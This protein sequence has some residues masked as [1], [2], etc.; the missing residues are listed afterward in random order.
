MP[1]LTL[2]DGSGYIFRAFHALPPLRR[3][4]GVPVGAVYGFCSMLFKTLLENKTDSMV[5]V[6]DA[7]RQT[8]RQDIYPDYKAH[9][10]D[11]PEDLIPQF[12]IIRDACSAFNVPTIESVG[13]EADDL[14][15]TYAHHAR[16][17]GYEVCII[18]S[19]KDLMQL[20]SH[21]ISMLDPI[22]NRIIGEAEVI[23]K[24]GVPPSKVVDVQALA[25]DSSDNVPGVPGI[26]V[27]TAAELI[28]TYG[29]LEKLLSQAHEI[30]QPKRREAIIENAEK[31]RISRQLVSLRLDAPIPISLEDLKVR[32]TEQSP[33]NSFLRTQGFNSLIARIER[34]SNS[35]A[36]SSNQELPGFSMSQASKTQTIYQTV[37]TIESLKT[38]VEKAMNTPV[39]AIDTETT[40]LNAIQAQLVGISLAIG[41][42]QACYIPLIHTAST[43]QLDTT[44]ALETLKPL[45]TNPCVLK[46]GHNIKYDLVVLAK[47]GID[48]A[49]LTDT[50]LMSY[51]LDAGKNGHGMDELAELHLGYNTIKF[52]DV[53]GSGKAMKTFDHVPIDQ[54]TAYAA[55]DADVTLQLFHVFRSRLTA[56]KMV[57]VFERL[58][59]PLVAVIASMESQGIQVD[60]LLL[61]RLGHEFAN[62]M[63]QLEAM[64]YKLAGR[65][66]NVA[67]PKQLGE[68]LFDE[69]NLNVAQSTNGSLKIKPPKKTKTGAYVTDVDVLESLAAQGHELPARVLEWRGLAKLK[70]TYVDALIEAVSPQTSRVHTSYML[71]GTSTGRIASSDPNLQNIPIRTEN[72]RK[73]R[74]AFVASPQCRLVSL[75]YSQIELRLLAHMAEVPALVEAFRKG[76]DIHTITASTMFGIAPEEI[77][78]DL[79][80]QAKAINFGII[81][82]IS[83]FGLSHQL[84]IAQ[85]KAADYIK[86]Y[87][88]TYP[89][90]QQYMERC[91]ELARRNGYVQTLW[92][93]KC[94]TLGIQDNNPVARQFAER[95]AINAPLQGSNADIIKRAMIHIP[96]LLQKLKSSAHMLLQVHDELVFEVPEGELSE[97][98]PELKK[99]MENIVPLKVPLV[100]GVGIGNNWDEAH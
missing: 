94:Y 79:R 51:V 38:W 30:K 6:F 14:I 19:D 75:D 45:L 4:D 76:N 60:R 62:Q 5:V 68:I 84:G 71:A 29:D 85:S 37:T 64:I 58:E 77:T 48:I 41:K 70:S 96:T 57:N 43:P 95:Q 88:E 78:A 16:D 66:F 54:A 92:G 93:R 23:E 31:A 59:R 11:P 98:I 87:F 2:I 50:M 83:P 22:K 99:L 82:G 44:L 42:D 97:T 26:G 40:S 39:V 12:Q 24:F 25:G 9:R 28:N 74:Q 32:P 35:I 55:E 65:T 56:E 15:A 100:V 80:R 10:P 34:Q 89:G 20:V 13:F 63:A 53:A 21:G 18:S 73:I 27:K 69:M 33:L 81:Y 61:D 86:T 72:G 47:Y 3:P 17:A 91:K 52:A 67:S 1:K 7:G 46:V 49:P 8:F 90:I 36:T